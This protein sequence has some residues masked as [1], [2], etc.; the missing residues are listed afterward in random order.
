MHAEI[1]EGGQYFGVVVHFVEFSQQRHL[2]AEPVIE[3]VAE[4][5][6]EMPWR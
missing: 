2:V 5:V 1:R 3:P 6:G 4:L